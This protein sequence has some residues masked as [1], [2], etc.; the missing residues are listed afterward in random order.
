MQLS[1]SNFIRSRLSDVL[2][3]FGVLRPRASHAE[4][5]GL[6]GGES[7]VHASGR[8][9]GSAAS[10]G[11][12]GEVSIR[13]IGVGDQE[14]L[15]V[16]S[17]QP[18]PLVVGSGR[19]GGSNVSGVSGEPIAT[20]SER[21]GGDGGSDTM[22]GESASS[23]SSASA[24]VPPVGSRSMDG[25]SNITGGNNRDST[26]QRYD[27]QQIARW[28]EQIL[29]FSLLLL[30]VFIRQHLQGKLSQNWFFQIVAIVISVIFVN[31]GSN[32]KQII[33]EVEM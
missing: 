21:R 4:A 28:I 10:T 15:R 29:P 18:H 19:D 24:S 26:Y 20:F 32:D 27:I 3:H 16:G 17:T 30:V 31:F 25:D 22:V 7:R 2:D 8:I 14:S 6:V 23:S 12:G 11:S 5:E 13:I 1:A 33:F 9:G